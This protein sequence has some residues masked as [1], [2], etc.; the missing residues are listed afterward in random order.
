[1]ARNGL[2]LGGFD[3]LWQDF[4]IGILV[5]A[6]VTVDQWIRRVSA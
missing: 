4:T 6:A 3:P 5:I 1:M 2:S